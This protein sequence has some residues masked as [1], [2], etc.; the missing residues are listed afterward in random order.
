M[1]DTICNSSETVHPIIRQQ[2]QNHKT[3]RV[4]YEKLFHPYKI[5]EIH[6]LYH[7]IDSEHNL[8]MIVDKIEELYHLSTIKQ[9]NLQFMH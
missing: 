5:G 4:K 6:T 8:L 9:W 7:I 2:T 3:V 1:L